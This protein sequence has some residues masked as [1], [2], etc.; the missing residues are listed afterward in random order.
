METRTVGVMWGVINKYILNN[1]PTQLIIL[2]VFEGI[3]LLLAHWYTFEEGGDIVE[4]WTG[5]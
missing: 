5:I 2:T 4:G 3:V 1:I